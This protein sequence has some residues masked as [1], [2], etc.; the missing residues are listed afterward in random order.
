MGA[1]D[2]TQELPDAVVGVGGR[3]VGFPFAVD[4]GGELGF[5]GNFR[6]GDV[7]GVKRGGRPRSWVTMERLVSGKEYSKNERY[8][9]RVEGWKGT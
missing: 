6:D 4:D 8:K 1:E 5:G 2:G 9:F 7:H 3:D